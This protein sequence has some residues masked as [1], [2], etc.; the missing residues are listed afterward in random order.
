[1]LQMTQIAYHI[2]QRAAQLHVGAAAPEL[3]TFGQP[4]ID[5][6]RHL[7]EGKSAKQIADAMRIADGEVTALMESARYK[8]QALDIAHAV[9]TALRVGPIT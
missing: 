7:A 1:M 4:E 9:A 5:V 6:L 2:H 8:L 3:E